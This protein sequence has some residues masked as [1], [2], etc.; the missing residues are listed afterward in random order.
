MNIH[1]KLVATTKDDVEFKEE[2]TDESKVIELTSKLSNLGLKV[3]VYK[4]EKIFSI[5]P[6]NQR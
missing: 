6:N 3:E 4:V 5:N 1:Y 2:L